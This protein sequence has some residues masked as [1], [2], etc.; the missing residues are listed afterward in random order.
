MGQTQPFTAT[1]LNDSQN[2]GV[3]WSLSGAGCSGIACGILSAASSASGVA[4]TYTVAAGMPS[5]ATVTVTVNSVTDTTR[6]ATAGIIFTPA[7]GNLSVALSPRRGGLTLLQSLPLTA[8]VTNDIGSAGV[9]WSATAGSFS[10][11]NNTTANFVAPNTPGVLTI[12]A[13]SAADGSKSASATIG[14]TDLPNVG[15][16]HNDLSRDGVNSHEFALTT[17]N[18][19]T[20]TFARLF[21]CALDAPAYA[22][23]LW[24]AGQ[25]I[26]NGT[27]T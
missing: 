23:P 16:Y 20:V 13:T 6:S 1:V 14:I 4:I 9:I 7:A 21:S 17:A 27:H 3:T 2:K 12:T 25:V 26:A 22:Q 5:P 15:T 19:N 11:Q 10:S 8:T 18:V 24:V